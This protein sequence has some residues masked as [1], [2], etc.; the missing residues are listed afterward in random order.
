MRND[1]LIRHPMGVADQHQLV[2]VVQSGG[3]A[4]AG[5]TVF[6]QGLGHGR[7]PGRHVIGLVFQVHHPEIDDFVKKFNGIT[8]VHALHGLGGRQVF[9]HQLFQALT[10][11]R[12]GVLVVGKAGAI[13]R[14]RQQILVQGSIVFQEGFLAALLHPVE[15]WLGDVDMPA[16][17]QLRHLPVEEGQQQGADMAAVHVRIGHDDDGM[18]TQLVGIEFI[19]TDSGTQGGD[20]GADLGRSQHLV[21]AGLLHV[22]DLA[23]QGQNGLVLAVAALLGRTTGGV[24]LHDEDF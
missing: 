16:L 24:T 22:Q 13:Q 19:R 5:R 18:V 9:A 10:L 21:K 11:Q 17:D 14:P 4:H 23:F 12:R 20:E 8:A 7:A 3:P 1:G 2:G 15:G 6:I